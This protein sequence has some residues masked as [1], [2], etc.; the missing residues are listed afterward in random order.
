VRVLHS[1]FALI[2]MVSTPATAA[3]EIGQPPCYYSSANARRIDFIAA[4]IAANDASDAAWCADSAIVHKLNKELELISRRAQARNPDVDLSTMEARHGNERC[5]VSAAE[6]K[7]ECDP[8]HVV[9]TRKFGDAM[10]VLHRFTRNW[11]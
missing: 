3:T 4:Y 5:H 11:K 8:D 7:S 1:G 6:K 9:A 2:A 10:T